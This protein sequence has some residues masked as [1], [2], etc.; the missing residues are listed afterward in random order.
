MIRNYSY[1]LFNKSLNIAPS[2][3]YKVRFVD[4]PSSWSGLGK[5]GY[6]IDENQT[7]GKK[8]NRIDW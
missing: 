4:S 2:Y 7:S 3:I 1:F 5:V 6:T 8:T